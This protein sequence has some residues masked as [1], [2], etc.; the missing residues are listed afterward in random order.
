MKLPT[1][2]TELRGIDWQTL[3]GNL[4]VDSVKIQ[5]IQQQ[6]PNN[7]GRCMMDMLDHWT[8]NGEDVSWAHVAFALKKMF[9]VELAERISM[10]Y[11][12]NITTDSPGGGGGGGGCGGCGYV[13][14]F[15]CIHY[16]YCH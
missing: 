15:V 2:C 4:G 3:A 6:H 12:S 7:V 5:T 13:C 1:L 8:K 11:C 9:K 14:L 10:K 16:C